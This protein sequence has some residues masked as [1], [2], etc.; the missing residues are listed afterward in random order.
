MCMCACGGLR[1]TSGII[2]NSFPTLF[3]EAASLGPTQRSP[4]WLVFLASVLWE[5]PCLCLQNRVLGHRATPGN[6]VGQWPKDVREAQHLARWSPPSCLLGFDQYFM[7][8]S[9]E[10]NRRNIWFAE[11]WEENFNCKLTSSG[12]QSDDSTRK[13]TGEH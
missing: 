3:I 6:T 2:L 5:F 1:L 8:R 13:C 9:L 4:L 11:F 7:T 12:G 10:N